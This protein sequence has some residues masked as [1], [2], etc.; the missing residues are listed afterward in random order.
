MG[1]VFMESNLFDI[2]RNE[3]S[4]DAEIVEIEKNIITAESEYGCIV[5][6]NDKNYIGPMSIAAEDVT[7]FKEYSIRESDKL[8]LNIDSLAINNK[9]SIDLSKVES[10]DLRIQFKEEK[11]NEDRMSKNLFKLEEQ[12]YIL[13][14]RSGMLPVIFNIGDYIKDLE[15]G[16]G[17][18]MYNN[19]YT[20]LIFTRVL[21]LFEKLIQGRFEKAEHCVK[22]IIDFGTENNNYSNGFLLGILSAFVYGGKT[23]G[24]NEEGIVNLNESLIKGVSMDTANLYHNMLMESVDGGS[25][26]AI[27]TVIEMIL[28]NDDDEKLKIAIKE[29]LKIDS[30][31]GTDVLCGIYFGLK[32]LRKEKFRESI[33]SL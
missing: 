30:I 23:Y 21:S 16:T 1:S 18:K 25:P 8:V 28:F 32:V 4:I 17:L 14:K 19:M 2:I 3:N 6:L 31:S 26:K 12:L 5:I 24:L 29:L 33:N 15:S 20:S 9:F 22:D 13:G 10:V 11:M 27:L 7:S